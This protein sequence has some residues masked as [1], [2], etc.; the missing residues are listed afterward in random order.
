MPHSL[1]GTLVILSEPSRLPALST[2]ALANPAPGRHTRRKVQAMGIEQT[3]AGV[4][5]AAT[6]VDEALEGVAAA[7][8][9]L[10][11]EALKALVRRDGDG[12][13]RDLVR[14]LYWDVP[15]LPVKTLEA[16]VGTAA[17]VRELAGP[18]PVLGTCDDCDTELRATSRTQLASGSTCCTSCEQKRRKASRSPQAGDWDTDIPGPE[19]PPEWYEEPGDGAA[20]PQSYDQV[21][22]LRRPC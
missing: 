14:R 4:R 7:K 18:G 16:A 8:Q 10:W 9:A 11:H 13:E 20:P 5:A 3:I 17:R 12:W 21:A 15:Q 6:R 22:S 19:I 1:T 2:T